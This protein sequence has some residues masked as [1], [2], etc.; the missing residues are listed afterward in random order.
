MDF[1]LVI[2][3][4]FILFLLWL[5]TIHLNNLNTVHVIDKKKHSWKKRKSDIDFDSSRYCNICELM[6][7]TGYVCDICD[8]AACDKQECV[9]IL[10]KVT[11]VS[12]YFFSLSI[13]HFFSCYQAIKMQTATRI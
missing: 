9:K 3:V 8:I 5:L 6:F 12:K 7:L 10:D 11:P 13:I 2:L 1:Y 4:F